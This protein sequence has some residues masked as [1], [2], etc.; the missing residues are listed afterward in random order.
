[1]T[2]R[3]QAGVIAMIAAGTLAAPAR[4]QSQRGSERGLFGQ[5][6]VVPEDRTSI[7]LVLSVFQAYAPSLAGQD[8]AA[9]TDPRSIL[10]AYSGATAGLTLATLKK[11]FSVTADV[12]STLERFPAVGIDAGSARASVT[13]SRPLGNRARVHF[14][15]IADYAPSYDIALMN[16]GEAGVV[17]VIER[18]VFIREAHSFATAAGISLTID[19]R[20]SVAFEGTTQYLSAIESPAQRAFTAGAR[21]QRQLT[22]HAS[23]RLGY[24]RRSWELDGADGRRLVTYDLDAGIEY[25]RALSFSKRT[26]FSFG[27]GSAIVE[28][29]EGMKPFFLGQAQIR[30]EIGRTWTLA[31][32]YSHRLEFIGGFA[33]PYL[34]HSVRLST[35]GYLGRRVD[36][37]LMTDLSRG[38]IGFAP[39]SHDLT[40]ASGSARLRVALARHLA[41]DS[42]Y[43]YYHYRSG[44]DLTRPDGG[45]RDF[46]QQRVKVGLVVWAP[47]KR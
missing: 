6:Q 15:Q 14:G 37:A 31:G 11:K 19:R 39:G 24:A 42:E 9:L 47:L 8:Q 20:S 27:T 22:K 10:G 35:G 12:Q 34:A 17:D 21:Y 16:A 44:A 32:L 46:N 41:L 38:T 43:A 2:L 36:L 40:G 7:D 4:A 13:L 26:T 23:V 25:N 29:A 30:R 45:P 33:D 28:T 5:R 18:Q 3:W 1:V